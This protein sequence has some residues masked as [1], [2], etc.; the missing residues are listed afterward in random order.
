[1]RKKLPEV[2]RRDLVNL[3]SKQL[4]EKDGEDALKYL[5]QIRKFTKKTLKD[6][7]IGYVP[8][9][10]KNNEGKHH[11]FAGKIVYPIYNQYNELVALHS[12]TLDPNA[13]NKF[14][15]ESYDKPFYLYG[16][17]LMKN[18]IIKYNKVIVTEGQHDVMAAYQNGFK[19]TVGI[20]GSAFQIHQLA[21]LLR[22]AKEIYMCFDSD[23]AGKLNAERMINFYKENKLNF[24]KC[25][26]INVL[27]P[28]E[29]DLKL[30]NEKKVDLDFFLKNFGS[31]KFLNLLKETKNKY[32]SKLK[33]NNNGF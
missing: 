23:H 32:Y 4:W 7:N 33:E 1:M 12:R 29:K 2:E 26:L 6:F 16:L 13:K 9:G 19:I 25:H 28:T 17:N 3:A 21:L 5:M 18:N 10:V 11:E 31:K 22:Y 24:Y 8:Y 20:L 30:L 14:F 27:L 15:H